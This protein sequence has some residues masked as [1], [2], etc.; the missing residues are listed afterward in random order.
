M[1]EEGPSAE[2]EDPFCTDWEGRPPPG[3]MYNSL[4]ELV[5]DPVQTCPRGAAAGSPLGE[6]RVLSPA[7][8]VQ[9]PTEDR[10][11]LED[12]QVQPGERRRLRDADS[13]TDDGKRLRGASRV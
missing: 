11:L 8:P 5:P 4:C 9:L 12:A 3:H 6:P 13:E 10:Q 2:R 1:P 7:P